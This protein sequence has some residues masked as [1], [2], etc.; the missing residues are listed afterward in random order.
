MKPICCPLVLAAG[1][2]LV[3]G[4]ARLADRSPGTPPPVSPATMNSDTVPDPYVWL[5]EVTGE[6]ALDWVREQNAL[7]NRELTNSPLFE[8]TR[9]RLLEILDSQGQPGLGNG[10]RPRSV[11][12]GREGELGLEG[13]RD[14]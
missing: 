11:G 5:E 13:S 12:G 9:L 10:A 4:C 3:A 2:S 1:L 8:P 14:P 7:S 6:K